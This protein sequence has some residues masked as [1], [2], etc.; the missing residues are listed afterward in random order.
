MTGLWPILIGYVK[1]QTGHW[2][3]IWKVMPAC[4]S[5][6]GGSREEG[7]METGYQEEAIMSLLD[8]CRKP[9]EAENE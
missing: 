8:R 1:R 4:P 5:L 9:A 3:H 2:T 6:E 7:S